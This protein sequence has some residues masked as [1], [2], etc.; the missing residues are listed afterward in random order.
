ME[1]SVP[2]TAADGMEGGE[3][4]LEAGD[5]H[6]DHDSVDMAPSPETLRQMEEDELDFQASTPGEQEAGAAGLGSIL[7]QKAIRLLL[8]AAGRSRRLR[9]RA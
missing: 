9:R 2:R 6:G 4:G 3:I 7:L 1:P 5:E 8:C